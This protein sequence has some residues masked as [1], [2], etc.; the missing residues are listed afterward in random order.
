[1]SAPHNAAAVGM[2]DGVHRGHRDIMDTVRTEAEALGGRPIVLTFASHP[3]S[4]LRPADTPRLLTTA[5]EKEA[6]IRS[7]MPEAD[8]RML[9]FASMRGV[10][11]R[12]FLKRL[13]DES[14]VGTMVMGYDN[15]FGCDGPRD[16]EA[17]DAL[18]RELGMRVVHVAPRRVD[19]TTASSSEVRR[20]IAAG[21]MDA[22]AAMLGR[23]YS[24]GG[25]VVHGRQIGRTIGFPTANLAPD[26]G[27]LL[28]ANGV[29]AARA[30]VEG[31]GEWPAMVN[32][33]RRPTVETSADAP[34]SVEAHLIGA[35]ADMYGRRM[36]LYFAARL[37]DER[38]FASVD[39]LRT[40][41]GADRE[42]TMEI[43]K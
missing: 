38:A 36:T 1:M 35:D 18:G 3:L 8:V 42:K 22:A 19:A 23:R 33:G 34:V 2:F 29:Y 40:Q 13:R 20:L 21:R 26:T 16:R 7:Y 5:A 15:R 9:D 30:V 37:R 6:L 41:L 14:G 4:E 31:A 11:A 43:C 39:E 10:S 12:D 32:I 28:P 25:T 17:Y 24:M 27:K